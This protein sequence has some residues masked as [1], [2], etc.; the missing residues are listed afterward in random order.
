MSENNDLKLRL[1]CSECTK[2]W[3]IDFIHNGDSPC[4]DAPVYV[5]C[6]S[7]GLRLVQWDH[8][9][10]QDPKKGLLCYSCWKCAMDYY[11]RCLR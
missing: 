1:F 10:L 5:G 11:K 9:I 8:V 6:T 4:C 3:D 7:C 2:E